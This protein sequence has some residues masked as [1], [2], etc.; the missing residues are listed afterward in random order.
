MCANDGNIAAFAAAVEQAAG[1]GDMSKGFFAHTLGT[2]LGTGWVRPDGSIPELPLEIYNLIIDL[3]SRRQ[4]SFPADDVRSVNSGNTG[5]P[6][7]LSRYTSQSGVFRLAASWLPERDPGLM[8]AA[9]DKGLFRWEGEPLLV[10]EQPEDMRKTCLEFFMVRA[11]EDHPVCEEIFRTIGEY[12]A[13]AW[14]ETEYIL[15]P[16]AKE[17]TLFGRLV[18]LPACFALMC[19]GASRRDPALVQHA[20]D[21]GLANTP[22]MRQLDAHPDYTVAQFAQAVGAI[23]YGCLGLRS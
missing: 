10:P 3:K 12:L 6:G 19:Q 15:Q 16:E 2:D 20:A 17:R 18:K 8:Q 9:L 14:Q 22:L 5:L 7:T 1:G 4:R 23:Y 21:G 11:T 13:V